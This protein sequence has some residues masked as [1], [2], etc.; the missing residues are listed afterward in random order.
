[1]DNYVESVRQELLKQLDRKEI[2][3][4]E[5]WEYYNDALA[6]Y[7]ESQQAEFYASMDYK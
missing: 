2:T 3:E 5:F 4:P 1:M 7:S 6:D